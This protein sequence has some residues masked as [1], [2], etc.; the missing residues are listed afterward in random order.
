MFSV[1]MSGEMIVFT[2]LKYLHVDK[3]L[4]HRD[5]SPNNILLTFEDV[6]KITDFGFTKATD[7]NG[8]CRSVVGTVSYWLASKLSRTYLNGSFQSSFLE[9]RNWY[10][11][12]CH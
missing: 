12:L 1:E 8:M 5:L 11:I 10:V 6:V 7:K 3:E 2:G 4:I 9:I